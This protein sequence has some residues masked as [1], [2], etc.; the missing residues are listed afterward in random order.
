M[1]CFPLVKRYRYNLSHT[2]LQGLAF[3][4]MT[5]ILCEDVVPGDQFSIAY[6]NALRF[7]PMVAPMYTRCR[8]RI[9]TFYVPYRIMWDNWEA[10]CMDC[11]PHNLNQRPWS[12]NPSDDGNLAKWAA[13]VP[14]ID[15]GNVQM[16]TLYDSLSEQQ[17]SAFNEKCQAWGLPPIHAWTVWDT[18]FELNSFFSRATG[19]IFNRFFRDPDLQPERFVFKGDFSH[20]ETTDFVNNFKQP[21]AY[22]NDGLPL[23]DW[24]KDRFNTSRPHPQDGS[25]G[26]APMSALNGLAGTTT[27]DLRQAYAEQRDK[28]RR[29]R[30][31]AITRYP[32]FMASEYGV[33]PTDASIQ[34]PRFLGS[35]SFFV[36]ISEVLTTGQTTGD[37]VGSLHGHG[38]GLHSCKRIRANI[39][40]HGVILSYASMVPE[41]LY[42]NKI[43]RSLM[44]GRSSVYVPDSVEPGSKGTQGVYIP[45]YHPSQNSLGYQPVYKQELGSYPQRNVAQD[46]EKYVLGWEPRNEDYR[47]RTG[48]VRGIFGTSAFQWHMARDFGVKDVQ[49]NNQFLSCN[50]PLTPFT[51]N[52]NG[53]VVGY[54]YQM[55][56]V[57]ARRPIPPARR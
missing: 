55:A 19:M 45:F 24:P 29:N 28:E 56:N 1:E 17:K 53:A 52:T 15:F 33:R 47:R 23:V 57:H 42:T 25:P 3:G 5:P 21:D 7:L 34:E 43:E 22:K 30:L 11:L 12:G 39:P 50:P 16:K 54:L 9:H 49:L 51:V 26:F 18:S 38:I 20:D 4:R 40:E 41:T 35:T 14:G 13:R 36:N 10:Y 27:E 48:T 8:V 31:G 2:N 44:R 6:T 32:D 37:P 46:A